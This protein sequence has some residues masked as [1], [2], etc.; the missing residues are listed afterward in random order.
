MTPDEERPGFDAPAPPP[1]ERAS[2]S[3]LLRRLGRWLSG[4]PESE[5]AGS[6]L[7]VAGGADGPLVPGWEI[8][9]A[10]LRRFAGWTGRAAR[11]TAGWVG[12]RR[13]TGRGRALLA[14]LVTL[15]VAIPTGLTIGLVELARD[16]GDG[17]PGASDPRVLR[18][19]VMAPLSGDLGNIGIA[20][21]DA[22]TLAVDDANKTDA[23]PGWKVELVAKDDLSRPDGGAAA[24]EAFADDSSLIGVV[25]PLSSTV[26][27]VAL[28]VLDAAGVPVVSPSNSSPDLTAQDASASTRKRPYS[29]Y[30]RLSGTDALQAKTGADYAVDT[31][32]RSR[33]L[34]IDGG[35]SYGESLAERFTRD[36]TAAGAEVVASYQVDGDAA[37]AAEVQSVADGIQTLNP[38]LIYTTTGYLFASALRKRMAAA[39]LS[40]PLLGTDAML[41]ARYLDSAGDTAEGDLATDLAVPISRLPAAG[42]FAAE[43]LKRWGP[44]LGGPEQPAT[45]D[46]VPD[47]SATPSAGTDGTS[48]EG[49]PAAS[50]AVRQPGPDGG[51]TTGSEPPTLTPQRAEMIPAL[52]AYAY[53]SARALLRAAAVVLPGRLA[54]DDGA[55]A[56]IAAQVGRGSFAGVTGQVSFDAFGDRRDPSSVVYAVLAGR[57]VPL[58]IGEP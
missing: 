38:D 21:R 26:A 53:D 16:H 1:A 33:I 8:A 42:A 35:P 48:S 7:V 41:S 31:L 55:R 54:V 11:A 9:V 2:A 15:L 51:G 3:S 52:A 58:V 34:V 44:V 50:A 49:P 10:G 18:L 37:A 25:G 32:R 30:F 6:E 14:G 23:I 24:A 17:V 57:F 36:A 12:R 22:V 5:R 27:R 29:R 20:V 56:A 19:G 43:F 40:V 39:Q 47:S 13:G 45:P 46:K 28:P 4:G